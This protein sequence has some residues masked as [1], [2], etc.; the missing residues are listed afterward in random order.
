MRTRALI[1]CGTALLT[2]SCSRDS[3]ALKSYGPALAVY[4][5]IYGTQSPNITREQVDKLPY[6]SMLG[7]IGK[8]PRSLLILGKIEESKLHWFSADRASFITRNG[9]VIQTSGLPRTN[10]KKLDTINTTDPLTQIW[11]NNIHQTTWNYYVDLEPGNYFSQ[12]IE[13]VITKKGKSTIEVLGVQHETIHFIENSR[14]ENLN[15][16]FQ[17]EYWIDPRDGHVWKSIQHY[18]PAAPPLNL[19]ITKRAR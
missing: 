18:S 10:L 5:A 6:A 19:W 4:E 7:Q 15:W 1:L 3:E 8:G 12:K 9:R 11:K 14:A 2:A 16:E 17:N 13:T